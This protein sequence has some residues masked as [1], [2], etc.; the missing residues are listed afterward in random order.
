VAR[1]IRQAAG[2]HALVS[3]QLDAAL[4]FAQR[5][6]AATRG[7]LD[8]PTPNTEAAAALAADA[9]DA[10]NATAYT[11]ARS[12]SDVSGAQSGTGFAEAMARLAHQQDGLNGEAQSLLPLAGAG[13]QGLYEQLRQLAAQQRALAQ[14]LERMEAAG[15]GATASGLAQEARDLAAQLEAGRLDAQTV[16]RQQRL[17][18]RLLDAG[19][20]LNSPEPD[21]Q[22]PRTSRAASADSV[23]LP[24][25]LAPG[26]TGTGPR[27]RYPT[28]DELARLSPEQRRLVLEYFRRINAP[29]TPR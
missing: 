7:E 19:R 27:M 15:G 13:G 25:A 9:V 23:H 6:M 14:Q 4:G 1:Q 16:H 2:R 10:L 12:L 11:L 18:R 3:P 24:V 26:A 28:W 5:Q 29:T 22:R 21:E 8:Q 20:T 17:Y